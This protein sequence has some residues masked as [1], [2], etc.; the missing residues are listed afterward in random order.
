MVSS[1]SLAVAWLASLSA[2]QKCTLQFDGRVPSTFNAA[3][4]DQNNGVFSP[5]NV[6]GASKHDPESGCPLVNNES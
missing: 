1:L 2:A 4:F 5:D 6:F 3:T